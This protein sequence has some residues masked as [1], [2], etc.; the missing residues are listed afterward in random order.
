MR[1]RHRAVWQRD[2]DTVLV[3]GGDRAGEV[4][5]PLQRLPG[6]NTHPPAEEP[7][8]VLGLGQRP[9]RAGRGDLERVV[10]Q[11]VAQLVGH[12]LA[13][14]QVDPVGVIDEEPQAVGSRVLQRDQ[15][16]RRIELAEPSLY[17]RLEV[18][19]CLCDAIRAEKKVGQAHFSTRFLERGKA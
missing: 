16:D 17:V 14:P 9:L 5:L 15:L 4:L 13:E 6:A 18:S 2:L 11:Q 7:A 3:G 12:P 1:N 10:D 19:H 8:E